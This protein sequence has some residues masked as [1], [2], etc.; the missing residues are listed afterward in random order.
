MYS[1][2]YRKYP[3]LGATTHS[4]A[5]HLTTLRVT[6]QPLPVTYE[7][8]LRV[9]LHEGIPIAWVPRGFHA[10]ISG[11]LNTLVNSAT[12]TTLLANHSAL[13]GGI[14]LDR[15]RT[16]PTPLREAAGLALQTDA[17]GGITRLTPAPHAEVR[18]RQNPCRAP[19]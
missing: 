16:R 7:P 19:L 17:K 6:R 9:G 10:F 4:Y 1:R 8:L 11:I 2:V 18:A 12:S 5:S 15:S 3:D 14:G 13:V